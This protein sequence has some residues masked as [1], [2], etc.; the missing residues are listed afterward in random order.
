VN[1]SP[2]ALAVTPDANGFRILIEAAD[3]TGHRPP[4]FYQRRV[5]R[6]GEAYVL[7]SRP[8]DARAIPRVVPLADGGWVAVFAGHSIAA[9]GSPAGQVIRAHRFDAAGRPAG[10]DFDVNPPRGAPGSSAGLDFRYLV[11]AAVPSS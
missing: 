5:D 9:P 1:G 7:N 6:D 10:P 11:V 8:I 2:A 3:D 4:K